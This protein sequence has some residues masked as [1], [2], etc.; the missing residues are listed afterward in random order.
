M[1]YVILSDYGQQN[2][3][4]KRVMLIFLYGKT[5]KSKGYLFLNVP[6]HVYS[7]IAKPNEVELLFKYY[8]ST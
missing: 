1:V 2:I 5:D 8:A 7:E 4:K 6:D 3:F